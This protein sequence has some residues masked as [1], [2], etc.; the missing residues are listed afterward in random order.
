MK[1]IFL[2][3]LVI[4][5]AV[6]HVKSQT[7]LKSF[8][9]DPVKFIQELTDFFEA[10][11]KKEGKNY[12]VNEF[13]PVWNTKMDGNKKA[14]I[15][16]IGNGML[17][18]R[19][20][21][22]EF[23]SFLNAM[24][25]FVN[26]NLPDKNFSEWTS[27]LDK[28]LAGKVVKPFVDFIS[29]SE[30]LFT[31]NTFYKSNTAEWKA[32][33]NHY[34]LYCD[35]VPRIIYASV[36]LHG[37]SKGDST[38]IQNSSGTYYPTQ[39]KWVGSGGRVT[40]KRC[41]LSETD[42]YADIKKYTISLKTASYIADSV[43]FYN[44][45]YF[46]GKP[47]LGRLTEKIISDATEKNASFPRFESYSSRYSIKNLFDNV[48]FDGGF[49]QVGSKF[50]GSGNKDSRASVV[51]K[52]KD[53][54]FLYITSGSFVITKDKLVA[55][56]ASM[57]MY[58]D[59]DSIYHP[60][61]N[62]KYIIADKAVT[63]YRSDE[64]A[65]QSP[66]T[67]SFHNVDMWFE[68]L[69]WKTEDPRIEISAV[70]GSSTNEA[71]FR[72]KA[73]FKQYIY[74]K[75]QG[76]S[77]INP[78]IQV[79]DFVVKANS[80][81]REFT[82]PQLASYMKRSPDDLRII[83]LK[84]SFYGLVSYDLNSDVV[85]VKDKL[86]NY[87]SNRAN[88]LDYDILEFD[89][90]VPPS[91]LN[92]SISLLNFDMT[93]KGVAE[94]QMSDS[95]NVVIYPKNREIILKK[96][97]N[98]TFAGRVKAGKFEFF[99][100][101]F[102]FDYEQ[103]KVNLNNVDSL[104]MLVDGTGFDEYGKPKQVPCKTVIEAING[105]L[106]IDHPANKSGIFS[107][108]LGQYPIFNSK[109][110]SFAYYDKKSI[111]KGVYKRDKFY[112]KLEAFTIDSLDN[113]SNAGLNFKGKL[114]SAGI[115]PDFTEPLTL[116]PDYSLGFVKEAPPGGFP[117]YGGKG[118][119]DNEVRLS[120]QGLRGAGKLEYVT[121]V[122]TAKDF[123]FF[124]DSTNAIAQN[125]V[126][127]EVK[128]G[129][130]EFPE[131]SGSNITMHWMPKLDVMQ[132][133]DRDS[134]FNMYKG[135]THFHGKLSLSPQQ[136]AGN[137]KIDFGN[138]EMTSNLMKFK[139]NK[140]DADTANFLLKSEELKALSFE[141]DNVKAHIDFDT[142]SGD[143]TSNGKGSIAK[144]PVNQYICY[145]DN[146]KW[147]MDKE[148][149]EVNGATKK[150]DHPLEDYTD[151]DLKG[152]ELISVN[153]KQDSLRFVAPSAKVDLKKNI[154]SAKDVVYINVADARI[155]PDKGDVIIEKDAYMRPLTN[156][157]ILANTV[158]KH[159]HI[160]N[161]NLNVFGRKSYAGSGYYDYIDE[162]KTK[163]TFYFS[164]V[165]VDTTAQTVAETEVA[166][167]SKFAL[168]PHFDFKGK[169]RLVASEEFLVF[170]GATRIVHA[171]ESVNKTW[172]QF[173][174][175]INPNAIYIPISKDPV[176]LDGKPIAVGIMS[177]TDSTH[178]YS[179]FVSKRKNK[180]DVEVLTA[181]GFLYFDK[182]VGEY[183][184]S[185]KEKLVERN[186][187]G[188]YVSLHVN[189]CV[190]YGEGK[191]NLGADLGQ[192]TMNPVGTGTHY[193]IPDSTAFNLLITTNFFFDD[194]LMEKIADAI[195]AKTDLPATDFSRAVYEKGLRELIG[196]EKADKAISDVNLYGKFKKFPDEL[197]TTFF[198]TDV[199]MKWNTKSKSYVS[200]GKIGIGNI[201]KT[202][203]NKLVDGRIALER[204]RTGDILHIYIQIEEGKWYYFEYTRG[205]MNAV[206]SDDTWTA[207]IRDIKSDK[208][209]SKGEKG[210]QPYRFNPGQ[211]TSVKVWLRKINS[212]TGE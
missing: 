134:T 194:G 159:H 174:A 196:K 119:Y 89:S 9:E 111:Q 98:Y 117:M 97:R 203:I 126:I 185:N 191:M 108:N 127:K 23:R 7:Q 133:Q 167:T 5:L 50:I 61:I 55:P 124:P 69:S 92:A 176:D 202:Q 58:L 25:A 207:A 27:C 34:Q 77:E 147:F 175:Q 94:I 155:Y 178:V 138:A 67:D 20:K 151:V 166:D 79:R 183:R 59:K 87:I 100:K 192:V 190:V 173:T 99:G 3:F 184:V 1:K 56:S 210:Q 4:L 156:A 171:C 32:E 198:F 70:P 39:G 122:T 121:S 52:R 150:P 86:F 208:R 12:V 107:K 93:V 170:S 187:P 161:A 172:F 47:L 78:M 90:N 204:K 44:Q 168:S 83:L 186:L 206:S 113:F 65:S 72:S 74:D 154:I 103:F 189:S 49:S 76:I 201:N 135:Q 146:F 130:A 179:A 26:N 16:K 63:V 21:T 84:F 112:Y 31:T 142:R 157:K 6:S 212:A 105:D 51:F 36:N 162:N 125:Y 29:M 101:E 57:T 177:T 15:Y 81:N 139:Q 148:T 41:G 54:K 160:Y 80:N 8:T 114:T 169:V 104:K 149:V 35:S 141:T 211:A 43:T 28:L 19:L 209:E 88:R 48:D 129:K 91:T 11:E 102:A 45:I 165:K 131:V 106:L 22:P 17:K 193:L 153:P 132:T 33:D 158:T 140:F 95:Q 199:K 123:L 116:Q 164:N 143:F 96:N 62:F 73:Y 13:A 118:K 71:V 82:V 137:G 163:K 195:N 60:E 38:L 182:G 85:I 18:K 37:Y 152:P 75:I 144:F 24:M 136:L 66:F 14:F 120:N 109:K 110:E 197:K 200:Y 205:N 46:K 115:F 42:V 181:D 64:G 188:N 40:W 53:K 30:N 68:Q 10:A 128:G 145:M 2:S 180:N